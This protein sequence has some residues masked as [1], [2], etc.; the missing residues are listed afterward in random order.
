VNTVKA[1][2]QFKVYSLAK[3]VGILRSFEDKIM[4]INT[5]SSLGNLA[6]VAKGKNVADDSESDLLDEELT[7]EDKALMVSNAKKFF[8]KN[9][10]R[11]RN[12]NQKNSYAEKPKYEG[13]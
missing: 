6:L 5:V 8:K 10:S 13:F 9:F 12:H 3:L 2:E 4:K 11:F 1:H 7:K